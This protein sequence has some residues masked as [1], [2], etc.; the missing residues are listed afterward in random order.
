[1][2]DGS[3]PLTNMTSTLRS[4][5][6]SPHAAIFFGSPWASQTVVVQPT[7][8]MASVT[9]F[10]ARCV[11]SI[12]PRICRMPAFFL[13][14]STLPPAASAAF[15][16]ASAASSWREP[17]PAWTPVTLPPRPRSLWVSSWPH[18]IATMTSTATA[19]MLRTRKRLI[20]A[21]QMVGRAASCRIAPL[22]EGG[23]VDRLPFELSD[24]PS[25]PHDDH[26]IARA[27]ELCE[28]R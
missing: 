6:L 24:Q 18:P 21:F 4:R 13:G 22:Y 16:P 3:M 9:V 10:S 2:S 19:A 15:L 7:L 25:L 12:A 17:V 11:D 23:I 1:M 27:D 28:L 8:L 14:R 5:R 20:R 26:A